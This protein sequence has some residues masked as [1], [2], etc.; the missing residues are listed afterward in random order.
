MPPGF[1]DALRRAAKR[2]LNECHNQL[3]PFEEEF[4]VAPGALVHRIAPVATPPGTVWS[5]WRQAAT[6]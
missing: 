2:F 3:R 1:P 6:G 5:A 4:E